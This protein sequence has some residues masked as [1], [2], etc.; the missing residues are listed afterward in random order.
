MVCHD[1][2]FIANL[3]F[4][5]ATKVDVK[6]TTCILTIQTIET[7]MIQENQVGGSLVSG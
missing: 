7:R 4:L 3:W 2:I 5:V 6:T 1:N